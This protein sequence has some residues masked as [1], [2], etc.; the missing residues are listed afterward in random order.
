MVKIDIIKIMIKMTYCITILIEDQGRGLPIVLKG[1]ADG[2]VVL[3][4][5]WH[6][7]EEEQKRIDNGRKCLVSVL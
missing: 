6:V 3:A 2:I 4:N 1:T 5:T 7:N